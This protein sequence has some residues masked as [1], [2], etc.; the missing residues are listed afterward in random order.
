MSGLKSEATAGCPYIWHA[1]IKNWV[2]IL[3]GSIALALGVTAFLQP[4]QIVS[5]GT[6][7]MA[8]LLCHLSGLTVG[9]LILAINIPLLILG[10]FYLGQGFVWRTLVVVVG[11]SGLVDLFSEVLKIGA[12]TNNPFLAAIYG[13]A[14][15]GIGVG[16]I[17]KGN[18]SAGGSTIVTRILANH[19]PLRPGQLLLCMDAMIVISTALVFGAVTPALWSLVSVIVTGRCIDLVLRNYVLVPS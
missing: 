13:G 2:Q 12:V 16:L 10:Y 8:I 7:G 14:A 9:T 1:E 6:P 17:L 15:I 3:L 19:I 11:L 5:G 4:N 18:A